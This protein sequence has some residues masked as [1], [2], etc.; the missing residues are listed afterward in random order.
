M[1]FLL[2]LAAT[3]LLI[4]QPVKNGDSQTQLQAKSVVPNAELIKK[5]DAKQAEIMTLLDKMPEPKKII[6]YRTKVKVVY[7]HDTLLVPIPDIAANDY[8]DNDTTTIVHDT[9]IKV[10]RKPFISILSRKN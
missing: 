7:I 3:I 10:I 6:Q 9:V 5:V 4:V 1:R 2:F 8:F